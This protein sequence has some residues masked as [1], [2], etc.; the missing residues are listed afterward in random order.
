MRPRTVEE[1]L[2]YYA[3]CAWATVEY[4]ETLSRPP[5]GELER[6]RCIAESMTEAVSK[7]APEEGNKTTLPRLRRK[8]RKPD[9]PGGEG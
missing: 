4:F 8:L 7:W 5:K 6:A 1:A 9:A 2:A 3:E